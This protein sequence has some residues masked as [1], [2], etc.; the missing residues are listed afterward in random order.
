[1]TTTREIRGKAAALRA[2]LGTDD[3]LRAPYRKPLA[4]WVRKR[5][6]STPTGFGGPSQSTNRDVLVTIFLRGGID[7]LTTVA[8]YGDGDYYNLRPNLGIQPPGQQDGAVDLDGFFGLPPAAAP[9]MTPYND[10]RLL[11]VHATGSTDPSRSHF[12]AM[13]FMETATPEQP[14]YES[15][16]WVAR[17][18][19]TVAPLGAGDL[20]GIGLD[21]LPPRML[22]EAP[23]TLPI[24]DPAVFAF[25]GNP[26][27]EPGRRQTMENMYAKAREPYVTFGGST[28]SSMTLLDGIDFVGYVPENGAQYSTNPFHVQLM[29]T[30]TLIKANAGVESIHI[31]LGGWDHHENQGPISGI[32]ANM[33]ANFASGIEAFYKDMLNHLECFTLVVQSEFGRRAAENGSAGTDHGHG[34]VMMVLGGHISGGQVLSTWPGLDPGSLDQGEDLAITLDYRDVLAEIVANRLGNRT[35]LPY[36]FPNYTPS[37][38]GFTF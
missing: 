37:Y 33:I 24:A 36:I 25:P 22:A 34:N 3:P 2:A 17:H 38:P 23:K 7:G 9:L 26:A 20:R 6:T 12:D 19:Q 4:P 27:T 31:D 29:R 35:N 10:N 15:S 14:G 18:L 8:P 5:R 21:E 11:I 16:G 32:Y 28:F 13:H 30:A 1:M